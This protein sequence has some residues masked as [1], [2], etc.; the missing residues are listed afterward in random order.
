MEIVIALLAFVFE[1]V[2]RQTDNGKTELRFH[3]RIQ[4]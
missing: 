1:V 2:W 3:Q 4:F